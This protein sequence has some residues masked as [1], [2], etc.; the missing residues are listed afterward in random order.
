[1]NP[2]LPPFGPQS[3]LDR[4]HRQ[5]LFHPPSL[6]HQADSA[7]TGHDSL[8]PATILTHRHAIFVEEKTLSRKGSHEHGYGSPPPPPVPSGRNR[9]DSSCVLAH[10]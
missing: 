5:A 8:R 9:G 6:G 4:H 7:A 1:M 2:T 10:R 3:G